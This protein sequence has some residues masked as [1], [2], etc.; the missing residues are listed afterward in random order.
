MFFGE[1]QALPVPLPADIPHNHCGEPLGATPD[2]EL[3]A[4]LEAATARA[5]AGL[6]LASGPLLRAVY[7]ER[8]ERSGRLLL[9]AHHLLVDGV[10][11]RVLVGALQQVC[12]QL[13]AGQPAQLPPKT[14]SYQQW[15]RHLEQHARTTELR[16]EQR[17]WLDLPWAR[18][19]PLPVDVAALAEANSFER[20]ATVTVR[21]DEAATT[22][23][24]REL[25][26]AHRAQV[27]EL[28]LYA[29]CEVLTA[30]AGGDTQLID[31][32]SHGREPFGDEI[33]LS[34]TV[35][36]FTVIAPLVLSLEG[37]ATPEQRLAAVKE[38]MRRMPNHGVGY[39]LL[40]YLADDPELAARLRSLP[41][42]GLSFNYLG[43]IDQGQA[44]GA[45]FALAAEPTGADVAGSNRR[46]HLIDITGQV[47]S[48]Q[49][50]LSWVYC[51]ATH[52]RET[53]EGLAE[54]HLAAL[55]ALIGRTQAG[56]VS[57]VTPSDFPLAAID[58][59]DLT[60]VL[61]L[62]NLEE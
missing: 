50:E 24:L 62:F 60:S 49:L 18:V 37:C 19:V 59:T 16:A 45:L 32:E 55:R 14:S 56:P 7:I 61:S 2:A 23:L 40:R 30:W 3:A 43:Q 15:A 38:Q 54:Q 27:P 36:W 39:G 25:S 33:D 29:L 31:L 10:S 53:V 5:Q 57:S 11:W 6:E 48:G 28:L 35:G 44:A 47:A 22:A 20:A 58:A 21:L 13:R 41:Q 42:P 4:A 12:E 46:A 17:Y 51:Q 8:G 9:V 26:E 1:G 34:R 52:R